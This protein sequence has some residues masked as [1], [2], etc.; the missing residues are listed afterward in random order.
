MNFRFR[1][2]TISFLIILV[3]W[4]LL[5]F[6]LF[7]LFD[8]NH[9]NFR[10][11]VFNFLRSLHS[12]KISFTLTLIIPIDLTLDNFSI[13]NHFNTI[14]LAVLSPRIIF[15]GIFKVLWILHWF[16]ITFWGEFKNILNITILILFG[17]LFFAHL[18]YSSILA[19]RCHWSL[20]LVGWPWT[21]RIVFEIAL[22]H[23]PRI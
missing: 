3:S 17:I 1:L 21:Q 11:F 2:F 23:D 14:D 13:T 22:G 5:S 19:P 16:T 18:Q 10:D 12:G 4:K 7:R 20:F 9:R 6:G 8:G 15:L